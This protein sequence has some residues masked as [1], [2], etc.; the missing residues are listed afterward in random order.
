MRKGV[1]ALSRADLQAIIGESVLTDMEEILPVLLQDVGFVQDSLY[2]RESL[3]KLAEAFSG[4]E[5]FTNARMREMLFNRQPEVV[6]DELCRVGKVDIAS[7]FPEKVSKLVSKGWGTN[8]FSEQVCESLNISRDN[9][10]QQPQLLPVLDSIPAAEVPFKQLK[11]YQFPVYIKAT[12]FLQIP[13]K[14][15]IVQMPTGSGKTRTSMEIICSY[16]NDNE[17]DVVWLAHSSELCEQAY[18]CFK[19][20]WAHLGHKE[21][22]LCKLWGDS[23]VDAFDKQQKFVVAGFQ[24]LHA[25][26]SKRKET[27]SSLTNSTGLV[28][29]DEAHRVLAPT[30]SEVTT[31]LGGNSTRFVGLTATPGRSSQDDEENKRLSHFFHEELIGLNCGEEDDIAY[32]REKKVLAR[33]QFVPLHTHGNFN[34]T[35]SQ[36]KHLANFFDFPV[37]FLKTLGDDQVRNVEILQRIRKETREGH[38]ILFFACSVKHSKYISSVLNFLDIQSAHIDGSLVESRR[39]QIINSFRSGEIDVLCNYGVLSTGFDDPK[40]DVVFISRPTASIVL[41]SQMIGRGLRGPAIGGTPF[42]KIV[43]VIDNIDG[44]SNEQ[45]VYNYFDSYYENKE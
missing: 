23:R 18:S 2:E 11:D 41:Y 17:K 24:K 38:K 34:L 21:I 6:I 13:N 14:R 25:D 20:V 5:M 44:Y 15:F 36:K 19:E 28:V 42:C 30:Y 9:I 45:M 1:K 35:D 32:L 33:A 26:Y 40:V 4:S 29:V 37:S 7:S 12:D 43:D 8:T 39:K 27:F 10:P 31:A 16:L 22:Q 3:V